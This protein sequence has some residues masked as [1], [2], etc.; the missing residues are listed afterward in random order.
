MGFNWNHLRYSLFAGIG[1]FIGILIV[2]LISI[3][4]ANFGHYS[5]WLIAPIGASAALVFVAPHSPYA[6]PYNIIFGN[7]LSALMG[8]IA[9][10]I[11]KDISIAAAI[12]VGLAVF[13]MQVLR[14]MHPS[15]GG[16]AL[17]AVLT[18]VTDLGFVF[19][20]TFINSC[21]L[22]GVAYIFHKLNKHKYPNIHHHNTE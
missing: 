8:I 14:V 19:F 13:F 3:K 12:A 4:F 2:S 1:S 21:I 15:G 5:K 20:P 11:T 9:L 6:Q 18:N 22:V 10:H 7:S 17:L 16:V